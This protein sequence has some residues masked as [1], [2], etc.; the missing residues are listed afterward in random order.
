MSFK[1]R[2]IIISILVVIITNK[3][4]RIPKGH[5]MDN[6]ENDFTNNKSCV[7]NN[8]ADVF[9]MYYHMS[10]LNDDTM[11]MVGKQ[12]TTHNPLRLI[13]SFYKFSYICVTC[14]SYVHP[15]PSCIFDKP[16]NQRSWTIC[17][18]TCSQMKITQLLINKCQEWSFIVRCKIKI[19]TIFMTHPL[20]LPFGD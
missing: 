4:Q 8:L 17:L 7:R 5:S 16:P 10:K 20:L 2:Y 15:I 18:S 1:V 3:R 14:R 11:D 13:M 19:A 6:P 9:Y 12:Q